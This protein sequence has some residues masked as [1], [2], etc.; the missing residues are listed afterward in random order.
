MLGIDIGR[1]SVKIVELQGGRILNLKKRPYPGPAD[2]AEHDDDIRDVLTRAVASMGAGG[3]AAWASV[4]GTSVITH[5]KD[6]PEME[7]SE[8]D[9]AVRLEAEELFFHDWET[10]DFDYRVVETLEDGG[11]KVMFIA[12]PKGL[13]NKRVA[14]LKEA[15]L[16]TAGISVNSLALATAFQ[17]AA[18]RG[19]QE[20]EGDRRVILVNIGAATTS[21]VMLEDGRIAVL[22]DVPFGGNDI[23]KSL[24][25]EFHTGFDEA[26]NIKTH[27]AEPETRVTDSV[28]R[29]LRPL[30]QQI[31]MTIG[32]KHRTRD[33]GD[34]SI[35]LAGGGC[36]APG[37]SE[38]FESRFGLSVKIFNPLA[39]LEIECEQPGD[40]VEMS[41]YAVAL[42]CALTGD[43]KEEGE[44]NLIRDRVEKPPT[45]AEKFSL[46][47]LLGL[48][49]TYALTI[50]LAAIFLSTMDKEAEMLESRI[51]RVKNQSIPEPAEHRLDREVV[52]NIKTL[53][54]MTALYQRRWEWN[55]KL[56]MIQQHVSRDLIVV[57]FTGR[58]EDTVRISGYANDSDAAGAKIVRDLIAAIEND[59]R[60]MKRLN[61]VRWVRSRKTNEI[62]HF[63]Q[64]LE[65]DIICE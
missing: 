5:L 34:N 2:P 9:G 46:P 23:N 24:M 20:Q 39:G 14:R 3:K 38:M 7:E 62:S 47:L 35:F 10:M 63:E 57:S 65:F 31:S 30:L 17:A 44:F 28:E 49:F 27:T 55:R 53:E 25:K 15:E 1:S 12:A 52:E 29:A 54:S 51:E 60:I 61:N 64:A 4:G 16:Y 18:E 6:F 36:R 33:Q 43:R 8:L 50:G 26:E 42:G 41:E 45:T 22:R 58:A 48:F 13:C 21:I 37:L 40:E 19:K 11:C 59:P 56:Q 32:L